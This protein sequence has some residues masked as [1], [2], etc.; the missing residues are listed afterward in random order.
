MDRARESPDVAS[1]SEQASEGHHAEYQHDGEYQYG[2][3]GEDWKEPFVNGSLR[4]SS[5]R[6]SDNFKAR[7]GRGAAPRAAATPR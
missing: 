3:E 1:P 7:T 4:G 2:E 5:T 6:R